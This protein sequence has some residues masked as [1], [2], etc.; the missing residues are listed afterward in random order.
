M[1]NILHEHATPAVQ[2]QRMQNL[3]A[4]DAGAQILQVIRN[5]RQEIRDIHQEIR[6]IKR[7]LDR[8]VLRLDSR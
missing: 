3:P 6:E 4:F 7:Q 5:I 8:L 2:V 1:G